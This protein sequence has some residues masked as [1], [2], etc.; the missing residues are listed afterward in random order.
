MIKSFRNADL[1]QLRIDL[2]NALKAVSVKHGIDIKIGTMGYSATEVSMTVKCKSRDTE[3]AN[4]T[5]AM[6]LNLLGLPANT[7]GQTVEF[8]GN[9]YKVTGLNLR[10][11][12][13]PVETICTETGK[14]SNF[15]EKLL[16]SLLTV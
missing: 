16:K 7:I 9:H 8:R 4:A 12:K 6:S 11:S 3:L 1:D 2:E 15:P 5:H 14:G 10:K 13:Y